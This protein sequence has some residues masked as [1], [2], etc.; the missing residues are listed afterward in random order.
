VIVSTLVMI[1][2]AGGLW[3][4]FRRNDWL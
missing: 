2:A 1:V 3:V 4:I